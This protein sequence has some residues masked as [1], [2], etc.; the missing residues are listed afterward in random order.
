MRQQVGGKPPS[1]FT[2][3]CIARRDI[4]DGGATTGLNALCHCEPG[5]SCMFWTRCLHPE[6]FDGGLLEI[7]KA[8]LLV[9]KIPACVFKP[10]SQVRNQQ[11][12]VDSLVQEIIRHPRNVLAIVEPDSR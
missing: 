2:R 10:L 5:R 6:S 4:D 7:L 12:Q 8:T 3:D 1:A 11:P 9:E